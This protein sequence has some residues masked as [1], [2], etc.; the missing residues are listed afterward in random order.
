MKRLLLACSLP[1]ITLLCACGNGSKDRL[2]EKQTIRFV[3]LGYGLDGNAADADQEDG[4]YMN[5]S[6]SFRILENTDTIPARIGMQFGIKYMLESNMDNAVKLEKIWIYPDSVTDD[7]GNTYLQ[8]SQDISR[9]TNEDNYISY[10][11]S[12]PY[13][14]KKGRWQLCIYYR[15]HLL[16][17][18]IFVLI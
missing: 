15:K 18:K 13:E 11:I 9:L 10:T 3:S 16:Y 12:E 7:E 2:V 17:R 4:N 8:E 6:S 1:F 5:N 14:I